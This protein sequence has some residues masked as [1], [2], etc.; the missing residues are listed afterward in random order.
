M[1]RTET[2]DTAAQ[3]DGEGETATAL[4]SW[5]GDGGG[6]GN[7]DA[8]GGS[9]QGQAPV[10]PPAAEPQFSFYVNERGNRVFS[11]PRKAQS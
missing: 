10:I 8:V 11:I 5:A 1:K 9:G 4:A 2:A 6:N 3:G 7:H